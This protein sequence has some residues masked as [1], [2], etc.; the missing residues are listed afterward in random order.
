MVWVTED[1]LERIR[2]DKLSAAGPWTGKG[3]KQ[4]TAEW[5]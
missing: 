1:K 2:P 3:L 5:N 4:G